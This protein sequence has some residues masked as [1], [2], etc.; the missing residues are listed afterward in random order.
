[1]ATKRKILVIHSQQPANQYAGG[2]TGV[3]DSE[4][5]WVRKLA[6]E[7][8]SQLCTTG[9]EIKLGPTGTASSAYAENVAWANKAENADA[10]L[11]ISCHSNASTDHAHNKGIGVYHHPNSTKGKAFAAALLPFLKPASASGR[12]Y[13][14]TITVAE[15][16]STK[17]PALLVEHEY[18]D[19]TGTATTGGA[20]WI[21][22][23]ANRTAL[24]K[25]YRAFVV[26]QFGDL[27]TPAPPPTP[28]PAP[29]PDP[30]AKMSTTEIHGRLLAGLEKGQGKRA[31]LLKAYADN[32]STA[33][34]RKWAAFLAA[35]DPLLED[36]VLDY[37]VTS[38]MKAAEVDDLVLVVL[39]SAL[40]TDGTMK[41]KFKRRLDVA[42]AALAHLPKAKVLVSGGAPKNGKTEAEVGRA[43]LISK[44]ISSGRII[45]EAKSGSTV[46]NARY[47]M[48]ILNGK[49]AHYV[50][51]SDS[52]HLRRAA[53]LFDSAQLEVETAGTGARSIG[54]QR[55]GLLA[56]KESAKDEGKASAAEAYSCVYYSALLLGC[57]TPYEAARR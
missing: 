29:T 7:I 8:V 22:N 34:S 52:S 55:V 53:L 40:N 3:N 17:P 2:G 6:E 44:G 54:L 51:V 50:L 37:G 11:L 30:P 45:T 48:A 1:M 23:A 9:H 57:V 41:A 35:A 10:D 49:Y 15:V 42:L 43:Y 36:L 21:R 19:W 27:S 56:Y 14:S 26:A 5:Y 31:A 46:G 47:S 13:Q 32:G 38:A 12:V 33:D 28:T 39:G 4:Q 20:E 25:A 16:A 24:A 18:H